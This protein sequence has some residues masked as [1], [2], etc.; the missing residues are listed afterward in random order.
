MNRNLREFSSPLQ[1]AVWRSYIDIYPLEYS[2][3]QIEDHE[4]RQS[5]HE[6]YDYTME[7]MIDFAEHPEAY[8]FIPPDRL[9]RYEIYAFHHTFMETILS[10]AC[11]KEK[12]GI[13]IDNVEYDS[14]IARMERKLKNSK[15]LDR[16]FTMTDLL[17]TLDRRGICMNRDE[18]QISITNSR[19][20]QLF[21]AA[22]LLEDTA[23]AYY[24][25]TKRSPQ[26]YRLLDFLSL[27]NDKRKFTLE[28][29]TA[30]MY[31]DE[32]E[33]LYRFLGELRK[34]IRLGQSCRVWY[35]RSA[36]F[37]YKRKPLFYIWWGK[38]YTFEI[39]VP[40]PAPDTAAYAFLLEEINKQPDADE[41]K[42]FCHDHIKIC[43]GCNA[44]CIRINAYKKDWIWFDRP[45]DKLI[46]SCEQSI[47]V[48]EFTEQNYLY[49]S[50]L[51][52]M[53]IQL[54]DLEAEKNK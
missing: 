23:S 54:I 26:Q 25:R 14:A 29:I 10:I 9:N 12:N 18:I 6:L 28:D 17:K 3:S 30:P 21:Y 52:D 39:G 19:Y 20:P 13:R 49:L 7:G 16:T 37:S 33:L 47:T 42:A 38:A 50:R 5:C 32:K 53:Y 35:Y 22:A 1:K 31:D 8:D 51:I 48:Y 27:G 11:V 41:F 24:R 43:K 46:R 36:D 34:K 40:L 15:I 45:M 4:L 2:I 44:N